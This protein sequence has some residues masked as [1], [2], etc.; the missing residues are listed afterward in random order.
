MSNKLN[1]RQRVL[2]TFRREE[3]D[4]IVWQPRIYYWYYGNRLQ[5]RLPEG[6][7]DSS[8]LDGIYRAIQS[9]DGCVPD[10]YRDMSMLEVY[11]ALG[12]SP[13]YPQEVLGVQL[14]SLEIDGKRVKR[15]TLF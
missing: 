2:R 14:F 15:T 7:A 13:R 12:A 6:Y 5:N 11:D 3:V 1:P 8:I 4:Q 10:R 9:Y